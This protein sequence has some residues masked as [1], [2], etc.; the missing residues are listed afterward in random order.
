M[1][2]A[3]RTAVVLVN[4]VS[5]S[6]EVSTNTTV[7][8]SFDEPIDPASLASGVGRL[9]AAAEVVNWWSKLHC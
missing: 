5:G 2:V 1:T 3:V 6:T 4:P 9:S 8:V 7:E